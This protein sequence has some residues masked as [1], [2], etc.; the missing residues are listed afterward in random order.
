MIDLHFVVLTDHPEILYNVR[1]ILT[2]VLSEHKELLCLQH[3]QFNL[4]GTY[5]NDR[6]NLC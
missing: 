5:L 1:I 2:W 6:F 4:M 3:Q